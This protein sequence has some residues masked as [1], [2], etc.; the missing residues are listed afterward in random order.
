MDPNRHTFVAFCDGSALRNGKPNCVAAYACLFP[1]NEA[2]NEVKVLN[3]NCISTNNRAEYKAALAAVKRAVMED[4]SSRRIVVI[5]TDSE[6]L[7]NTM[8]TYIHK[9]Q[10]NGWHTMNGGPVKNRDVLEELLRLSNGRVMYRH[11]QAHT[12]CQDWESHWNNKADNMARAAARN[13][14]RW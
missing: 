11:V 13:A 5:F 3:E 4:P 14:D 12:G 9:W 10:R 2:W 8:N 7:T 6:L 1:Q